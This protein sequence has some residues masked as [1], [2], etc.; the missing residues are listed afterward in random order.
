[1]AAVEVA[2][3]TLGLRCRRSVPAAGCASSARLG[4]APASSA[5][6]S[7]S[8]WL[9]R[10]RGLRGRLPFSPSRPPASPSASFAA[11]SPRGERESK[12]GA[13]A[14]A[15]TVASGLPSSLIRSPPLRR[16][17]HPAS[18]AAGRDRIP[19]PRAPAP[20]PR[21]RFL[22]AREKS[23]CCPIGWRGRSSESRLDPRPASSPDGATPAARD[24]AAVAAPRRLAL[25]GPRLRRRARCLWASGD[26]AS[27]IIL[28]FPFQVFLHTVQQ[29]CVRPPV[30]TDKTES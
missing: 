27:L 8:P 15:G 6:R 11:P 22:L 21:F 5:A 20:S 2:W 24:S 19:Q 4:A 23:I 16:S 12:D 10:E 29:L 7:R 3:E 17:L 13:G 18:T 9:R 14:G 26:F 30:Y 1:M 25:L 28:E